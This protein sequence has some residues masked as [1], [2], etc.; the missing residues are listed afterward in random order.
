MPITCPAPVRP[1]SQEEFV[2]ID[3]RVMGC[4]FDSQNELGRL[5][6]EGIYEND[7]AARLRA[8]GFG[9]V[10]QQVPVTVTHGDFAKTFRLDLVLEGGAVYELKTEARLVSD[11][12]AQALNYLLLFGAQH[13]KL[14]N[15]RTPQVEVRFVNST[16]TPEAR[17]QYKVDLR[18]WQETDGTSAVLRK[19]M[20]ALLEDWG[21]FL[22]LPLYTEA[23][24]HFLGGEQRVI[25]MVQL[26][27]DGVLLGN[28][29][30]HLA[31]PESA[32]R[33]TALAEGAEHYEPHLLA[34]LRHSPLRAIHW[35][36]LGRHQVQFVTLSK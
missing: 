19:R 7:L 22:E 14:L 11:H 30:I 23:L 24:V 3:Y 15:F 35:I 21:G 33:L 2:Q 28:Q 25:Q 32:F 9:S 18:R 10:L 27:R 12:E 1:L 36:N 13:G 26:K 6:D 31:G 5:C 20:L 17:R 4:A 8:S 29:R 16:L 34:L